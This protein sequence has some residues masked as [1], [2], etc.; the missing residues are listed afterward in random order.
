MSPKGPKK[1]TFLREDH[2]PSGSLSG[3]LE[4]GKT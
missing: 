1:I 2:V 4:G 3:D